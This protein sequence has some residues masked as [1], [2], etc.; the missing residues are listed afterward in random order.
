MKPTTSN[1]RKVL[2]PLAT[3]LAAGAVAVGSGASFTAT[4]S[5]SL[6]SVTAG[7]LHLDSDNSSAIF[8]ASNIKPGDVTTGSVKLTNSGTLPG[9]V[10][11]TETS[12]DDG[13][14]SGDVTVKI[15]DGSGTQVFG[16]TLEALLAQG[17]TSLAGNG[18]AGAWAPGESHTYTFQVTLASSAGNGDQDKHVN[19]A[20]QWDDVQA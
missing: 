7:S 16:G 1:R 4:T 20:F 3:L 8:S 6:S 15:T 11:F 5:N 19:A 18:T 17:K 2:V 10:S 12:V 13:F 9:L 14:A